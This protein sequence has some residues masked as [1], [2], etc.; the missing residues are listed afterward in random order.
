MEHRQLENFEILVNSIINDFIVIYERMR[1]KN[2]HIYGTALVL[3]SDGLTA[4]M[5]ISTI[6]S[7]NNI[8][9]GKKWIPYEW[10]IGNDDGDVKNGIN[11]FIE[12]HLDYY[13]EY[14][15]P[16]FKSGTYDYSK[17]F[18]ENLEKFT[19]GMKRA[20][21]KLTST[22]GDDL[23]QI[24]FLLCIPGDD[25]L[26]VQSASEINSPSNNLNDLLDFYK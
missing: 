16:K 14:I 21:E 7:L 26:I 24:V 19:L 20:K 12:K 15:A 13:D 18:E 2:E 11:E 6:E 25:A 9:Q 4:Y 1:K 8:H 17:D 3:D 10:A 22:L 5:S 23:S